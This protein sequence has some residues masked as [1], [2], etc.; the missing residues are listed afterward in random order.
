MSN[1]VRTQRHILSRSIPVSHGILW[2]WPGTR[3]G[4]GKA[5]RDG[6]HYHKSRLEVRAQ[7]YHFFDFMVMGLSLPLPTWLQ[8]WH[9]L[10]FLLKIGPTYWTPAK[11]DLWSRSISSVHKKREGA[12]VY[13]CQD[14]GFKSLAYSC[15]EISKW[16]A[17]CF[18]RFFLQAFVWFL[19]C[20]KNSINLCFDIDLKKEENNADVTGHNNILGVLRNQGENLNN[21]SK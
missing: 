6:H 4:K 21:S 18:K 17:V 5:V 20:F 9:A 19:F 2:P 15:H 7:K 1:D 12:I 11:N 13:R 3:F 14:W 8:W 10:T 16:L